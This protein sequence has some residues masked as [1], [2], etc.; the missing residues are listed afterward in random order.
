MT[1]ILKLQTLKYSTAIWAPTEFLASGFSGICPIGPGCPQ[2][3][4]AVVQ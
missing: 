4:N 2:A 3:S 1:Q